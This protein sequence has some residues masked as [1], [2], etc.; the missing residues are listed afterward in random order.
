M[1]ATRPR[2]LVLL[3]SPVS[4]SLSPRFQGAALKAAGVDATY[5]ALDVAPHQLL[6]VLHALRA[7]GVAGNVTIP[8]KRAVH[9]ACDDLTP[10]ARAAGAVNTFWCDGDRLVGDNTDVGGFDAAVTALGSRK[11]GAVVACVGAGGAAAAVC[12][13]TASWAGARVRLVGRNPAAMEALAARFPH[14]TVADPATWWQGVTLAVNAT[15]VGMT[16]DRLPFDPARLPADG[17]VMDLVYRVD[18]TPLVRAARRSGRRAI[19]G[20]EMLLQQGA[21]AFE[22]WFGVVPDLAAMRAAVARHG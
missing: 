4:H 15:P 2:R 14:V 13:A 7:D 17:D 19:D 3:G 9:D 22:R 1:S 20:L 6:P 21:L 10:M 11:D 18:E 16:D 5:E 12:L 8:H